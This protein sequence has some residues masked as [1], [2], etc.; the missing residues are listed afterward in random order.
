MADTKADPVSEILRLILQ[1]KSAREI[2]QAAASLW[3]NRSVEPLI[4]GA[5]RELEASGDKSDALI[6]AFASEASR[7]IY[8]KAL[9][10]GHMATALRAVK[11]LMEVTKRQNA[12][13]G[14]GADYGVDL[15][16][17]DVG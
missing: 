9:E 5:L 15:T 17:L 3:P 7:E 6:W 16:L 2:R 11:V 12:A 1:G 13:K 4:V 8:R 14:P 10:S